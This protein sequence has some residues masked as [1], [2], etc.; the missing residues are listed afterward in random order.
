MGKSQLEVCGK[1][2][3]ISFFSEGS[4]PWTFQPKAVKMMNEQSFCNILAPH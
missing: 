3:K 1:P 4:G 2:T